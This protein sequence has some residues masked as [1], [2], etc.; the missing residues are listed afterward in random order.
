MTA[1][2]YL[3]TKGKTSKERW[4]EE[5]F[6]DV[7]NLWK[8]S[9]EDEGKFRQLGQRLADIEHWKNDPYEV[10]RYFSEFKGDLKKVEKMFR[11]MITWRLKKDIDSVLST[12]GEPDPLFHYMPISLLEGTDKDG[13]PIY[14]GTYFEFGSSISKLFLPLSLLLIFYI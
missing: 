13:D 9:E 5:N 4:S 10:I 8:L 14:L 6:Q 3:I 1:P 2:D 12:Y 11:A 7:V